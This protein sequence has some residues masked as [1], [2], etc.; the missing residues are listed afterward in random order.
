MM[1][2]AV[3]LSL[4]KQP[5]WRNLSADRQAGRPFT[6]I[7]KVAELV[8]AHDSKSCSPG[9]VGSSPTFGTEM[10]EWVYPVSAFFMHNRDEKSIPMEIGKSHLWYKVEIHFIQCPL[11]YSIY[12]SYIYSMKFFNQHIL[13]LQPIR[14]KGKTV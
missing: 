4:A 10:L 1:Q 3:Y 12:S 5:K 2:V 8:D 9:S 13:S 14:S 11:F 6:E 7:A